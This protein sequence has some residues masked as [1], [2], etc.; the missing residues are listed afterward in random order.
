[1]TTVFIESILQ[2]RP[3]LAVF[4]CD[5]TLWSGDLRVR[6]FDW[7]LRSGIFTAETVRRMRSRYAGYKEGKISEDDMCG[8]MVRLHTGMRAEA[9]LR[10]SDELSNENFV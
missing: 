1:M 4:D 10:L 9:V 2:L 6:F 8:E 3:T 5:G 7:E